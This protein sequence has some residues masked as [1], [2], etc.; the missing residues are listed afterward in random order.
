[1]ERE[2]NRKITETIER[3]PK[4]HRALGWRHVVTSRHFPDDIFF[5]FT[6]MNS[7]IPFSA[8]GSPGIIR[9]I[10]DV[11]RTWPGLASKTLFVVLFFVLIFLKKIRLN[12]AEEMRAPALSVSSSSRQFFSRNEL[13]VAINCSNVKHCKLLMY[14]ETVALCSDLNICIIY[15]CLHKRSNVTSLAPAKRFHRSNVKLQDG[16]MVN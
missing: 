10:N 7:P 3:S 16:E 1:M 11:P 4:T 15:D 9:M 14:E 2:H 12:Q 8:Y 13:V 6:S 5:R